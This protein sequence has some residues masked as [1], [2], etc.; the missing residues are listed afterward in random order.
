MSGMGGGMA[1]GGGWSEAGPWALEARLERGLGGGLL[2]WTRQTT[3]Q[4]EDLLEARSQELQE[5]G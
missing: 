3:L 4:R 5:L 2:D 1:G